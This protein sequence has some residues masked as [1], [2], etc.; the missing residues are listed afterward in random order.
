MTLIGYARA[1]A[2]PTRI[3]CSFLKVNF[4]GVWSGGV[5]RP[6]YNFDQWVIIDLSAVMIYNVFTAFFHLPPEHVE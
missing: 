6:R 1:G 3:N 4:L 2:P 5:P